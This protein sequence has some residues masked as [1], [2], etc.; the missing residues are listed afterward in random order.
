MKN[1]PLKIVGLAVI[2]AV[3]LASCSGLGKLVKNADKITYKVT[4]DPME[5]HG[6]SVGVGITGTY[7]AKVF[8]KTATVTVIPVI[9]YNGGEKQLKP[10]VLI[11][12]KAVGTGQ[13]ISNSKG[14]NFSYT[15]DKVGY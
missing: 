10:V 8:P 5:M 14:G 2:T 1:Q 11:G 13:T 6:D 7:P 3:A 15:S 9:K 4:P 12:E